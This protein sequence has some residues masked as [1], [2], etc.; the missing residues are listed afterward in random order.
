MPTARADDLRSINSTT[1][2]GSAGRIAAN[3]ISYVF[4]LRGSSHGGRYLV[5]ILGL[6]TTLD[7]SVWLPFP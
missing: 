6:C 3:E 2:T 7:E 4:G 5:F 1:L